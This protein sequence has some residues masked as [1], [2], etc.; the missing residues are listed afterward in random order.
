M[1][2]RKLLSS[3]ARVL[4]HE[5]VP[6][7]LTERDHGW[8]AALIEQYRRA[9]GRP[10]RELKALL[11]Q[12]LD[13]PA[14]NNKRRIAAF[15]LE[16]LTRD[17][18]VSPVSPALLRGA[19][20]E[21]AK[22]RRLPRQALVAEVAAAHELEPAALEDA[23]FADLEGER[24]VEPLAQ[25]ISSLALAQ[26]A[27]F[28]IASGLV[29]R[30]ALLS[31]RAAG[32]TRAL[33]RHAQLCGL[34]CTAVDGQE[35]QQQ[36]A[37]RLEVSGPFALFRHTQVYARALGSLLPPLTWCREFELIAHCPIRGS[38]AILTFVLKTG[39]PIGAGREIK[40]SGSALEER[41]TRDFLR[42][43]TSW[44]LVRQPPPF[45]TGS[46]LVF[47]D[48]EIVH[49]ERPALRYALEIVGYWTPEYLKQKLASGAS[50]DA[51]KLV[52]CIDESKACTHTEVPEG[53][54]VVR[55]KRRL[56]A[57]AVLAALE[58]Q[59]GPIAEFEAI[60]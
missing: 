13:L 31:I 12:P 3:S 57:R 9:A 19:L 42:A 6:R 52:L 54:K 45:R 44:N 49:R 28:L 43:T 10:R 22:L 30:A 4:G 7:Y 20:F 23:L 21:A 36:D 58:D 29:R 33:V 38:D 34:I 39:D 35:S 16:A 32:E 60:G 48:F 5:L 55:F 56:D 1:L 59:D 53:A 47:P 18:V 26:E 46:R 51:P 14:P 8:L 37:V 27:N 25:P 11:A 17:A 15:A 40:V 24:R 41:F 2:P 50:A